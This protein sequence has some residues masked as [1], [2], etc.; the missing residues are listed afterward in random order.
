MQLQPIRYHE[1]NKMIPRC[2]K[3]ITAKLA[4]FFSKPSVVPLVD[5]CAVV[6]VCDQILVIQ[7]MEQLYAFVDAYHYA[8]GVEAVYMLYAN[9]KLLR[10]ERH[11]YDYVWSANCTQIVVQ[12][13]M[14]RG[15]SCS[16]KQA[17][18]SFVTDFHECY[19]RAW[20]PDTN[21]SFTTPALRLL[22]PRKPVVASVTRVAVEVAKRQAQDSQR[23][24]HLRT[25]HRSRSDFAHI[26]D[27]EEHKIVGASKGVVI[28]ADNLN[29]FAVEGDLD[30]LLEALDALS[31]TVDPSVI[32]CLEDIA[33]FAL[34]LFRAKTWT[35]VSLAVVAY[36]KFRTDG[37]LISLAAAHILRFIKSVLTVPDIQG[38]DDTLEDIRSFRAFIAKWDTIKDSTLGK[39]FSV[40]L[41]YLTTFGALTFMGVRPE[42]AA[43]KAMEL[44]AQSPWTKLGFF[45]AMV[46]FMTMTVE[47]TIVFI[48]TGEW[49]SFIHGEFS[50]Q[51]WYDDAQKL[52]RLSI[53][54]GN[55]EAFGTT[56]YSF[57]A[58]LKQAI[59]QG[60]TIVKYSGL[61]GVEARIARSLLNDLETLQSSILST[62]AAQQERCAPFGLLV[63]GGSSVAKSMFT[64]MLFYHFGKLRG[65]PIDDEYRYVRNAADD[66]WSGFNSQQ[67]CI[68][69][70]DIGYLNA[71]KAMEDR[72]LMEII[73]V[74][75][76]VPLVP[77]QAALED[78]GRTPVRAKFVVA[79]SNA[80]DMNAAAYFHC[81]LAVQR[82]LPFVVTVSP[83]KEY[84]RDDSPGMVDPAKIPVFSEQYP[85]IWEIHVERVVAAG[86]AANGRAMARHEHVAKF[87][88]VELFLDWFRDVIM[89]FD[90]IQRKSM[91]DDESMKKFELCGSCTRVKTRCICP[92]EIQAGSD[93][94]LPDGVTYGSSWSIERKTRAGTISYF[95]E[96]VARD[97]RYIC[98]ETNTVF[99]TVTKRAYPV[100]VI[101][102]MTVQSSMDDAERVSMAS[103]IS[104]SIQRNPQYSGETLLGKALIGGISLYHK[105]GPVRSI[106]HWLLG[107]RVVRKCGAWLIHKAACNSASMR[108]VFTFCAGV[109][110]HVT[111]HALAYKLLAGLTL[112]AGIW[113]GVSYLM[114]AAVENPTQFCDDPDWVNPCPKVSPGRPCEGPCTMRGMVQGQR[115]SV[116]A[117][118]FSTTERENV[119]KKDN[120]ETTSFDVT[121]AQG[122]YASLERDQA[123]T[124]VRRNIVRVQIRSTLGPMSGNA[125]CVGGHLWV[126]CKHFFKG[127]DESYDAD[128]L[129]EPLDKGCSRNMTIK[130]Y[131]KDL[132]FH[133][134]K[135]QVWFEARGIEVKKNIVSLI[136]KDSLE[137]VFDGDMISF[138][139]EVRS[140][141][142]RARAIMCVEYP[143]PLDGVFRKF[144]RSYL[145][146]DSI[147]GDCGGVLFAHKPVAVIL[148]LHY[149]GGSMN[150]GFSVPLNQSD[151][152]YARR[153]FSRPLIQAALP[154]LNASSTS[155]VLGPLHFKSP[156]RFL[157]QGNL[158]VYGS[159][160][161][162]HL[163]PRTRVRPTFLS[164]VIAEE[165]G[166]KLDV[167]APEL[168]DWRPWRHAYLDTCNQQHIVSQS[169]IDACV[170]AYVQDVL[171]GLSDE[172]KRNMQRLS[173]YD[174][175]NGIAGVKYI[176]K[177]NFNTSMGEPHNHSKKFHLLPMPSETAPE[178]KMF[179]S[180]TLTRVEK[181]ITDYEAGSRTCAVFSGQQKDEARSLKKLAEGK[182]RIFTACPTDM[183]I[184]VRAYLLPFVKVFQENPFLFE[185]APG[186]VCQSTEWTFFY[187][188]LTQHGKDRMVAGDYGKFDKK[189]LAEWILAAFEVIAKI[190]R[191]SGWT[192][193]EVLP[194]YAMAEDIAFPV[195]NMN[196]DLVMFFGSNPSGHPLTVIINCIVN[197]L[198]MRYCFKLL[199]ERVQSGE[200]GNDK[201]QADAMNLSLGDFKRLVA[202]LTYGD[203]NT[204]GVSPKISWFNHTALVKALA[205]IGVE[206]TMADKESVSVPFIHID[207]VSFLKRRWVWNDE[208]GAYFCPLEEASIRK[209]LMIA[210]RNKTVSD[211]KHMMDVML[212]ANQEWFWYGRERFEYEQKFLRK[213]A[214]HPELIPFFAEMAFPTW[215][216]LMARFKR[217]SMGLVC[218]NWG[219]TGSS[220][221]IV[222]NQL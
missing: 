129:F 220:R 133:P 68:Q 18:H 59:E 32:K 41:K 22:L 53:G 79:T 122:N 152:T 115:A 181:I 208:A 16:A 83:K 100:R 15:G 95:Y 206:Y 159:F 75:N 139:R 108:K 140:V 5:G 48:K 85:D 218:P 99:E 13:A 199:L 130:L 135:D 172:S 73:Q 179:D 91:K 12:Y 63:F 92:P 102:G 26:A 154:M 50:Y 170:D 216:D 97:E 54:L 72:S 145:D 109:Q 66:F 89:V 23:V 88:D 96:Y 169:D 98:V 126:T 137:G 17:E 30:G 116:L 106:T 19:I 2:V 201:E 119:W 42:P 155:K 35:D 198:Y 191:A 163:K 21:T 210:C 205:H 132:M 217:A 166:W 147:G 8:N 78:K 120:Y 197:A 67:W 37:A 7:T 114:P 212:S 196:G 29:P 64:R 148:G 36:L 203:D 121:P 187:E 167:G 47:R 165:R 189:M 49:E 113:K 4:G 183:A 33:V 86:E 20:M 200:L 221:T 180:E 94:M 173:I 27:I 211:Q 46:D 74:I 1:T 10:R 134:D 151:V 71:A 158:N 160:Q 55:L 44:N 194:I 136:A 156:I 31:G 222:Q 112:A 87:S 104:E 215:D 82:R 69:M 143:D 157:E 182:I 207:D 209:M 93:V 175:V 45:G 43:Y 76:S 204:L 81:P 190:L 11:V 123:I 153:R 118:H 202:L 80:K 146:R 164:D 125:L 138:S 110:E 219:V 162:A 6:S 101:S 195:V 57:V 24:L 105:Y 111:R 174:A 149:M 193:D 77:N 84:A 107:F 58:E 124:S 90:Q 184:A 214:T 171:A 168:G 186:A 177:M 52:K 70:D 192:D 213:W 61:I 9:G 62:K 161:G 117:S 188:Y 176:D 28:Q 38:L 51:K 127:S 14:M 144:W 103:I 185:G 65:L 3:N 141:D 34:Q 39:K 142:T 131:R 60:K 56:Y 40:I 178:G 25:R 150:Y 128:F